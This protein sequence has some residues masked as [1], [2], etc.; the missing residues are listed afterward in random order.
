MYMFMYIVHMHVNVK[1]VYNCL[2][3][4]FNL[5]LHRFDLLNTPVCVAAHTPAAAEPGDRHDDASSGAAVAGTCWSMACF[6]RP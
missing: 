4:T 6:G 1:N 5:V 3:D 2:F